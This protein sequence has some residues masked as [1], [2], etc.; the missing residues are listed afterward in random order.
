[1][2][3]TPGGAI[4]LEAPRRAVDNGFMGAGSWRWVERREEGPATFATFAERPDELPE[5]T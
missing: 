4:V 3:G 2:S 1:M 5:A